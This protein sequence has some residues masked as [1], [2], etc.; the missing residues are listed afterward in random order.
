PWAGDDPAVDG[1]A[2]SPGGSRSV[3]D[4]AETARSHGSQGVC[5]A[6]PE[7]VRPRLRGGAGPRRADRPAAALAGRDALR[8]L[9]DAAVDPPGAGHGPHRSGPPGAASDHRR[10]R[11]GV[12]RARA[13]EGGPLATAIVV[14]R[15]ARR[16]G[17]LTTP[18]NS[19]GVDLSWNRWCT[20]C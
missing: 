2:V 17:A 19:R 14:P 11:G 4:G 5:R 18:G 6:R 3:R 13:I 16:A 9:D 8:R 20:A 15:R 7:P 1:R 12:V 10:G